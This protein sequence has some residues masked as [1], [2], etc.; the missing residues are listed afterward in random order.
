MKHAAGF[1]VLVLIF[2]GL[3][4]IAIALELAR[5]RC[6]IR[7][8]RQMMPAARHADIAMVLVNGFLTLDAFH[9]GYL[10]IAAVFGTGT[11]LQVILWWLGGGDDQWR[12]LR[13]RIAERVAAT[14]A[15][16]LAV[17][18]T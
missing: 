12:K 6:G 11:V 4:A 1:A 18:P 3:P 10:P 2:N 15:G 14:T 5:R 13:R 17:V 16:R 8:W 7:G 9:N